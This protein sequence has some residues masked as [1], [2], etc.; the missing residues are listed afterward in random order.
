MEGL[1]V[2]PIG[3]E[4]S[5]GGATA[6]VT[7]IMIRGPKSDHIIYELTWWSNGARSCVWAEAVELK[8][9]SPVLKIGFGG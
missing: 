7:G 3:S 1:T 2:H 5:F 4:V 9:S 8:V 6:T